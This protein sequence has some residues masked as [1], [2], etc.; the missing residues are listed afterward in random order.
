MEED[1]DKPTNPPFV[2]ITPE[3]QYRYEK[4][5]PE[6]VQKQL[7][8]NPG[9]PT[10]PINHDSSYRQIAIA[11]SEYYEREIEE[12]P[13]IPIARLQKSL[14]P[15]ELKHT[16]QEQLFD[17]DAIRHELY[18]KLDHA[19]FEDTLQQR[20]G[21]TIEQLEQVKADQSPESMAVDPNEM[22]K[23]SDLVQ[24]EGFHPSEMGPNP[25]QILE[26]YGQPP[27]THHMIETP[28]EKYAQEEKESSGL[29]PEYRGDSSGKLSKYVEHEEREEKP[30]TQIGSGQRLLNKYLTDMQSPSGM[31]VEKD[32]RG[33]EI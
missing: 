27:K 26:T 5:P 15:E 21:M 8:R 7:S 6:N 1:K 30:T 22:A 24:H 20:Y 31:E 9:I 4:I 14:E 29:Y 11:G 13:D 12:N 17:E 10:G 32:D 16:E 18:E 3:T 2:S 33:P 28:L 19:R 23:T 25:E